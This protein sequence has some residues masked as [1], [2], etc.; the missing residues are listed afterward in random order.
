MENTELSAK[1]VFSHL[2]MERVTEYKDDPSKLDKHEMHM[3]ADMF[4]ETS[5]D[6]EESKLGVSLIVVGNITSKD[7]IMFVD[8]FIGQLQLDPMERLLLSLKLAT[9]E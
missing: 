1:A 9:P 5:E 4:S 6:G 8:R 2:V 7:K 3:A